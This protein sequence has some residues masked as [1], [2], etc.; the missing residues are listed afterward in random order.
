M[1]IVPLSSLLLSGCWDRREINDVAFVLANSFDVD[2]NG[3]Y[4]QGI[5]IAL[6]GQMGGSTGGGGGT[7]GKNP[8]YIDAA[9]GYPITEEAN[10]LQRRMA[11]VLNY[12]HR[13]VI[14][15]GE[16]LARE[17]IRFIIDILAR[18]PQN[19]ITTYFVVGQGSGE[20]LLKAKPH[21]ER[22]SGE[23]IREILTL[24]PSGKV[25]LNEIWQ[26]L[27]NP[28]IDM[29]LPVFTTQMSQKPNATEEVQI[30]GTALFSGQRMKGMVK[31]GEEQTILWLTKKIQ[32]YSQIIQT[33][34]KQKLALK[35]EKGTTKL[36]VISAHEP[37]HFR[38]N[39]NA[40]GSILENTANIDLADEKQLK[41]LEQIWS[42]TMKKDIDNVIHKMQEWKSDVMGSGYLLYQTHPK[43]WDRVKNK[44][45]KVF[46]E[47]KFDVRVGIQLRRVG[48]ITENVDVWQSGSQ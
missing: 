38:V 18:Y 4:R 8:Y 1:M 31:D 40:E 26:K 29:T 15:L 36:E 25:N 21:L 48:Q 16:K 13:R 42:K 12:S 30:V 45:Y 20:K 47:A 3:K 22:F 2:T 5:I 9:T 27:S 23:A 46:K 24:N 44:W 19:R 43:E 17:G 11:R 6:P 34:Q 28:G 14:I 35:I 39:V 7:S 10:N 37:L 33:E 32:R 41:R